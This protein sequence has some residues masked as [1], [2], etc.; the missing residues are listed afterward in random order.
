[1]AWSFSYTGNRSIVPEA[2][3]RMSIYG[4]LHDLHEGR[5]NK[6]SEIFYN[7]I[8][9]VVLVADPDLI[10]ELSWKHYG[11]FLEFINTLHDIYLSIQFIKPYTN[12][13]IA[14]ILRYESIRLPNI[15]YIDQSHSDAKQNL[16]QTIQLL[17]ELESYSTISFGLSNL[18][19]NE[20]MLENILHNL[21]NKDKI[22]IINAGFIEPP[23]FH[24]NYIDYIHSQR[25]NSMIMLSP[26]CFNQSQEKQ[27]LKLLQF[28][29]KYDKNYDTFIT[30]ICL[31]FGIIVSLS[32]DM[33]L[34]YL[35][36][37]LCDLAHAL[38]YRIESLSPTY[39]YSFKIDS[40]D[41]I[42]IH[43]E[44]DIHEFANEN[45]DYIQDIMFNKPPIIPLCYK[46]NHSLMEASTT[47]T[48][49]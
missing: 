7:G 23:N 1:M 39:V 37:N 5:H 9:H 11:K 38:T 43:D 45:K 17:N 41:L 3:H 47:S 35:I 25:I 10:T 18:S 12:I 15:L 34:Q 8:K 30:K 13:S 2:C 24:L 49:K 46:T 31:E 42:E 33:D 27:D 26:T 19:S 14:N 22:Q 32:W 20:I 29:E 48:K 36:E 28:C 6:L 21:P 44:S 40:Q 4:N 16:K